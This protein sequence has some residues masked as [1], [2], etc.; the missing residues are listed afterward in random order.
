MLKSDVTSEVGT[1][2]WERAKLGVAPFRFVGVTIKTYQACPDAPIQPGTCCDYCGTGIM[3][4]CI[5]RDARGKEF[6]VGN[7]CVR[8]T[9]DAGLIKAYKNS[10]EVRARNRAKAAARDARV[11]IEWEALMADPASVEL[12][13]RHTRK[14]WNGAEEPWGVFA[15]RAWGY[16]GA[17]GRARYLKTAKRLL[18]EEPK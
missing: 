12:L 15:R 18:T 11:V 9:G 14:A 16:C 7:D 13:N 4:V 5:I 6:K 10:P 2:V 1:H 17:S 8:R 3:E